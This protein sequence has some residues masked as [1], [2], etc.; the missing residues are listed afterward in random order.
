MLECYYNALVKPTKKRLMLI[1]LIPLL[2]SVS[3]EFVQEFLTSSRTGSFY[4][5]IFNLLG[6]AAAFIVFQLVKKWK[7]VH[8][9]IIFPFKAE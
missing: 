8:T 3:L 2:M 5:E 9:I 4:D 7:F 6:I 1:N